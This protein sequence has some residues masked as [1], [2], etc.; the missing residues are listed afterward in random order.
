MRTKYADVQDRTSR[1]DDSY[2]ILHSGN[3][4]T[5][6]VDSSAGSHAKTLSSYLDPITQQV[7]CSYP[8]LN[9][10]YPSPMTGPDHPTN[11]SPPRYSRNM[12][13]LTDSDPFFSFLFSLPKASPCQGN[14]TESWELHCM[15]LKS[16]PDL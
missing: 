11:P 8:T 10:S 1:L 7:L 16:F 9:T 5:Y 2:D 13:F 6:R 14:Y 4:A 12:D 15:F 3:L